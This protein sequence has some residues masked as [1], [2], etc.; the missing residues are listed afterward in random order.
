MFLELSAKPKNHMGDERTD[1]E[2]CNQ[3]PKKVASAKVRIF[4]HRQNQRQHAADHKAKKSD[5]FS[6][7]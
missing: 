6:S 3:R 5:P 2:Q 7:G 4:D 1:R